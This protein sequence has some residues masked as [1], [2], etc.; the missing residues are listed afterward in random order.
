MCL[1]N[2]AGLYNQQMQSQKAMENYRKVIPLCIEMGRNDALILS[3]DNLGINFL[4]ASQL[5]SAEKYFL[6][7]NETIERTGEKASAN[8]IIF[9]TAVLSALIR[10]PLCL[11]A[12]VVKAFP[13][14]PTI[15]D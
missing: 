13:D 3:Y 7:A 15:D 4:E 2:V 11:R 9:H 14:S 8:N 1:N 5:D 6:L 10:L 12:S